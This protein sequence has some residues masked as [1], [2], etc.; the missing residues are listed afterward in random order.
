MAGDDPRRPET[1]NASPR[2]DRPSPDD[3]RTW[4]PF[5]P[6]K[7]D[8]ALRVFCFSHAGGGAASYLPWNGQLGDGVEV[9]AIQLPGRETRVGERPFTSVASLCDAAVRVL[10]P[11]LDRPF[12]FFGHSMGALVSFETA[13]A[14]RRIGAPGPRH[15]FV[16][17][18]RAPHLPMRAKVLYALPDQEFAAELRA[19]GGTPDAL[20]KDAELL[21]L[22]IPLLRADFRV[23]D[24][25]AHA[26]ERPLDVPI[27]AFGG[28][29]DRRAPPA[30]LA[31]WRAHTTGEFAHRTFD[32]GHFYLQPR[33]EELLAAIRD[34]LRPAR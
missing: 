21:D 7:G 23:C 34:A 4:F 18:F 5:R 6:A 14:L 25:Y 8:P 24:T 13:R 16:S 22:F 30:E 27:T 15:L 19:M 33:R 32:G 9:C 26:E 3:P 12:V 11:L 10:P 29:D 17:G 31:E 28:S 20:F 1:M 2:A